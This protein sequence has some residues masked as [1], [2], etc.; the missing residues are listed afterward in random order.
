MSSPIIKAI[1]GLGNPGPN[2]ASTRHNAGAWLVEEL[3]KQTQGTLKKETK[4]FGQYCKV[5]LNHQPLH[6]LVPDTFMNRSG[7]AVSALCKFYK[8]EPEQILV[9]HDE[10][11]FEPG[12]TRLKHSGGH[13]GHNGLR[14]IIKAINSKD[15]YRARIGIGHPG[16]KNDVSDYVLKRPSKDD[17]ISI[18][19]SIDDT[20]RV[21]DAALSGD[22]AQAMH[23]LHTE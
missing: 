6:L 20:L 21:F 2:Y 3:A 8:L 10:L 16:N 1:I 11:D 18:E 23:R 12:I 7:Q 13:G 15:F 9:A 4:L 14:D 5:F 17:T 19:R 22:M